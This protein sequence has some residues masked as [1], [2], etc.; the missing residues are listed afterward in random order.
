MH[1]TDE[2]RLKHV[3]SY[4]QC[5]EFVKPYIGNMPILDALS[6][7]EFYQ[8][9]LIDCPVP[10]TCAYDNVFAKQG[11]TGTFVY[12]CWYPSDNYYSNRFINMPSQ[13]TRILG[14]QL[15]A[16]K[17][18]GFLHWGFN[19]YNSKLSVMEIDPYATTDGAGFFPSGDAFI[20]YPKRDGVVY[21]LRLELMKEC[22]QDYKAL[23]LLECLVGQESVNKILDEFGVKGFHEY[24]RST[25]AH[26]AFREY[27]NERIIQAKSYKKKLD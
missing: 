9:G 3:E 24:P 23:K 25:Q 12:Y 19:F 21:S 13:R 18:K 2:P 11:I 17:S 8:Q 27:V 7:Y 15:Y 16:N 22:F 10:K 4:R 5:Y 6:D 26:L 20:V 14:I 1:L